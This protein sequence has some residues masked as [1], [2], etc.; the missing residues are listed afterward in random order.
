MKYLLSL[1]LLFFFN[2]DFHNSH[3]L[4]KEKLLQVQV[5]E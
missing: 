4:L 1:L 3:F 2:P 5:V